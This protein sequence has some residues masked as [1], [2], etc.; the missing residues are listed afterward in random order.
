M[1]IQCFSLWINCLQWMSTAWRDT[2][3]CSRLTAAIHG[4]QPPL[5]PQWASWQW[6]FTLYARLNDNSGETLISIQW[7]FKEQCDSSQNKHQY[8]M[9]GWM[10]LI[11]MTSPTSG[12]IWHLSPTVLCN[13]SRFEVRSTCIFKRELVVLFSCVTTGNNLLFRQRVYLQQGCH[14]LDLNCNSSKIT[15]WPQS[16]KLRPTCSN[17]STSCYCGPR[18]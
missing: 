1:H 12:H 3:W 8:K 7:T 4:T 10:D 18:T 16:S 17:S 2:K 5:K 9:D 13:R 15:S 14:N 6:G 11:Y